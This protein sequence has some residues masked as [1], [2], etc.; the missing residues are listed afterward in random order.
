MLFILTD[1]Q[2]VEKAVCYESTVFPTFIQTN[3]EFVNLYK[4]KF[5]IYDWNLTFFQF[6][7]KKRFFL[8]FVLVIHRSIE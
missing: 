1:Y 8:F 3:E 6:H 2:T 7:V 5:F 4:Y